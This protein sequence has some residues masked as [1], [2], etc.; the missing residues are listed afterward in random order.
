ME[1]ASVVRVSRDDKGQFLMGHTGPDSETSALRQSCPGR[2]EAFSDQY[3]RVRAR[4]FPAFY[5]QYACAREGSSRQFRAALPSV[6]GRIHLD[7]ALTDGRRGAGFGT[8]T[9]THARPLPAGWA[10]RMIRRASPSARGQIHVDRTLTDRRSRS[11]L[12]ALVRECWRQRGWEPACGVGHTD[13]PENRPEQR[14]Y[15]LRPAG[16][17]VCA[18][19][20]RTENSGITV[21]CWAP[22]GSPNELLSAR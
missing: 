14:R 18:A 17:G 16:N 8:S 12:L 11:R 15:R 3:A 19:P 21:G 10:S 5:D 7:G 1:R 22:E 4:A 20:A 6:G 9:R 13:T 2:R